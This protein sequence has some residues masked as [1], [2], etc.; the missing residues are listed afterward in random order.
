MLFESSSHLAANRPLIA[1]AF[2]AQ[3]S[4][5]DGDLI[6]GLIPIFRPLV[7]EREGSQFDPAEFSDALARTYGISINPWA[8][9]ELAPRLERAGLLIKN[10]IS[11]KYIT[12]RY[13]TIEQ[14]FG[15]ISETEI[16]FLLDDFL[17]FT[18]KGMSRLGTKIDDKKNLENAFLDH[19]IT[20]NFYHI[21]QKPDRTKEDKK[22]ANTLSIPKNEEQIKW[23]EELS[24]EG[25]LDV[26]IASYIYH[27]QETNS[28][29]YELLVK[30]ANGALI[31]EVV[32]NFQKPDA[33]VS[34]E[35]LT[36]ILDAPFIMASL[37]LCEEESYQYAKELIEKLIEH[38]ATVATLAHYCEEIKENLDSAIER[39]E[40]GERDKATDRRLA[41]KTFMAYACE[42][43]IKPRE[44]V[45]E[46]SIKVIDYNPTEASYQ[47]FSDSYE[48]DYFHALGTYHN[49]K[50]QLRDASSLSTTIRLRRGKVVTLSDIGKC[51]YLFVTNNPWIPER[52]IK[53]LAKKNLYNNGDVPPVISDR[54]LAGLIWVLYGGSAG[55]IGRLR[56]LANCA[57]ALEARA[58]VI[59][60]VHGFL[61]RA[62]TANATRFLA[63]MTN[64]RASHHLMQLSF[65][66][67]RLVTEKNYADI[68]QEIERDL[69][70]KHIK[71]A[72]ERIEEER[73]RLIKEKEDLIKFI[74]GFCLNLMG[75]LYRRSRVWRVEFAL[76]RVWLER[77]R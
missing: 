77:W 66:E 60:K 42:V 74:G 32:L 18:E 44:A 39:Y 56:L 34:L 38:K 63:A 20:T 26:L 55:D 61:Q 67:S 30:I 68:F 75:E 43:R 47:F 24:Y 52:T 6:S 41:D 21:Q 23:E 14:K 71:I 36:V 17:S 25:T 45:S 57:Q 28:A 50:A 49:R 5:H 35:G 7:K 22:S 58:D 62:N 3:T 76:V 65:G 40:R 53:Y 27:I 8:T 16:R 9:E 72:E 51:G 31:A 19:L 48:K 2:L 15:E 11:E 4:H 12:Y 73:A 46:Q 1:Y 29:L 70:S 59:N 69:E 54:Y 10:Q 37:D 64:E 33:G 13:A